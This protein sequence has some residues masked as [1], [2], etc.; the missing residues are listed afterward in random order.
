[1]NWP[2]VT[3]RSTPLSAVTRPKARVKPVTCSA[4]GEELTG[5]GA[6]IEDALV[7]VGFVRIV[8]APVT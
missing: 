4:P 8:S 1:M 7:P 6:S 2:A 3:V 5:S